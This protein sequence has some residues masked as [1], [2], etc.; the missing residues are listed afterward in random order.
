MQ[1]LVCPNCDGDESIPCPECEGRGYTDDVLPPLDSD[2]DGGRED[3][4]VETCDR[5]DGEGSIPCPACQ[6]ERDD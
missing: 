2:N 5:C 4:D 3:W 6:S 1:V